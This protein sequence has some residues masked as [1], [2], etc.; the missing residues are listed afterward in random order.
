MTTYNYEMESPVDFPPLTVVSLVPSVTESLFE[1]GLGDRLIA[2][3]DYCVYPEAEVARLPHIGGTKNPDVARIIAMKPE[4]VIVNQEENRLE[5]AE[6]LRAAGIP[7]WVTF[8]R[9]VREAFNLLW[10]MMDI[11]DQAQMVERV[12]A[13]EWMVDWLERIEHDRLAHRPAHDRE[14]RP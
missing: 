12:R 9:T 10:K 8:P 14:P 2:V 4:L 5:D 3:T 7:V 6:A 13:M 11:F 1:L